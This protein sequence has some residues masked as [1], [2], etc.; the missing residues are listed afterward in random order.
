MIAQYAKCVK[1]ILDPAFGDVFKNLL[2]SCVEFQVGHVAYIGKIKAR[3]DICQKKR[4]KEEERR[5]NRADNVGA[6]CIRP[7]H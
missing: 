5:E 1:C 4:E 3:Q 7:L 6:N 2:V